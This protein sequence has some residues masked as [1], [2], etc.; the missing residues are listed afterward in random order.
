[1]RLTLLTLLLL[2][3]S[4]L[5][6]PTPLPEGAKKYAPIL[7]E[8]I[9]LKWPSLKQRSS[10]AG[11]VEQETCISLKHSKCWSPRAEL[12]TSREHGVG[13]GQFTTAYK[14]DGTILFDATSDVRKLDKDLSSWKGEGVWDPRL[15]LRALVVYDFS[16]F[17]K[18][19]TAI[20]DEYERLAFMFASYNGGLGGTLQDRRVCASTKGCDQN[21]WF[22]NVENT[23][24]KQKTKVQGYGKSFFEINREYPKNILTIRRQKYEQI[25]SGV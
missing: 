14:S 17:R 12:K 2:S 5:A 10:L 20:L 19:P 24:L 22:G 7:K 4:V 23:S 6:A 13:F 18:L 11:Q 21:K 1:M 9:T 25:M 3:G 15:Q 16:I 8:E